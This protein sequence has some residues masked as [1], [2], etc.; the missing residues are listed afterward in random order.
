MDDEDVIDLDEDHCLDVG[1][2]DNARQR[3]KEKTTPA[4]DAEDELEGGVGTSSGADQFMHKAQQASC[5]QSQQ[6]VDD[7]AMVTI[8][9]KRKEV[10]GS[11]ADTVGKKRLKQERVDE[12]YAGDWE[13]E[14]KRL[15]LR[16][17]YSNG[18]PFNVFRSNFWRDRQEHL[19]RLSVRV[20]LDTPDYHEIAAEKTLE[21]ERLE[22]VRELGIVREP[23]LDETDAT[24]LSDRSVGTCKTFI[25]R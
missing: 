24:I 25:E 19:L 3:G 1:L 20:K 12:A 4:P 23:A 21:R 17:V 15:F 10:G 16:F 22:L 5:A 18:I 11:G 8:L 7:L 9:G 14:L 6:D 13:T 2:V